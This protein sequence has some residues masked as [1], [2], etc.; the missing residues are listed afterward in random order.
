[1]YIADSSNHRIRKVAVST[2]IIATIAGTGTGSYSGD[3]GP[4]TTA[5]LYYPEGVA[6]DTAGQKIYYINSTSF[7]FSFYR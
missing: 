1:M 3:N 4:A 7:S 6:T 5:T 2:G